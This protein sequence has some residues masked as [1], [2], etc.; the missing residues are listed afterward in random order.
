LS[1]ELVGVGFAGCGDGGQLCAVLVALYQALDALDL[2]LDAAGRGQR[3]GR[4]LLH[5]VTVDGL[6]ERLCAH[7]VQADVRRPVLHQGL[8]LDLLGGHAFAGAL[9]ACDAPHARG[10]DQRR[11]EQDGTKG[12]AQ[13]QADGMVADFH[14]GVWR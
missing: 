1:T 7:P 6:E 14:G 3:V 12:C 9:Q 11:D 10:G 8:L 4:E 2:G 13:A 5:V